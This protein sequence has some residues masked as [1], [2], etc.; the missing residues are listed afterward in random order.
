M[1]E[2]T[3]ATPIDMVAVGRV[4]QRVNLQGITLIALKAERV[5]P[6]L[7]GG[8]LTPTVG[9]SHRVVRKEKGKLEVESRFSFQVALESKPVIE[10]EFKYLLAYRVQGDEPV[11]NEDAEVFATANGAYHSWPFVRELLFSL[12]G[13]M[14]FPPFLLP[15]LTF[16]H[17]PESAVKHR[18][19]GSDDGKS[20]PTR[21][22]TRK[23]RVGDRSRRVK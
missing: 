5:P 19:R 7:V 2:K 9:H 16:Q 20:S 14:G 18:L 11:T 21:R 1:T 12:T 13:R 10:A 6:Q 23:Q 17:L 15:V 8:V 4:A 3:T 22:P